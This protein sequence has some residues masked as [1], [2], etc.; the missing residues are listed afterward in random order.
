MTR[1]TPTALVALA[2]L[3]AGPVMAQG[4]IPVGS[5]QPPPPPKPGEIE[6]WVRKW[7]SIGWREY[8]NEHI[9][10]CL[11]LIDLLETA[12]LPQPQEP[13]RIQTTGVVRPGETLLQVA[14]RYG[15]TMQELL[16]LNPSLKTSALTAGTEVQLVPPPRRFAQSLDELVREG[17]V[18]PEERDRVRGGDGGREPLGVGAVQK[19]CRNGSLSV[20]EC[21]GGI[22]KRWGGAQSSTNKPLNPKE[23]ALLQ[24]IRSGGPSPQWRTYG[25]CNYDWSGWRLHANGTRTTAADCGGTALRWTIGV[26]C[27]RLLVATH[28][29]ASGWSKWERPSGPESRFRR[30]EDEMVAALC[31]NVLPTTPR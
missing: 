8:G 13:V 14:Q 27:A 2:L 29:T 24:R 1:K 6:D 19:A 25:H 9:D 12:A 28:T 30:G 20:S 10:R 26:S 17:A 3:L 16:R 15:T 18:E 31:A 4:T 23:Q 11:T 5:K 21:R 7:C 22:V